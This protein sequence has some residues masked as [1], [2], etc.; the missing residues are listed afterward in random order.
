MRFLSNWKIA[1]R[2]VLLVLGG[3]IGMVTLAAIGLVEQRASL[4]SERQAKLRHLVETAHSLIAHYEALAAA[5]KTSVADAQRDALAALQKLRY[6]EKD[7]FWVNDM[8]PRMLMH[9]FATKLVG[10]DL[11]NNAD[12]TGLKLFVEFVKVVRAN[13]AGFVGYMWPKPGAENPVAKIS[14]VKGFA[15]WGWI[16]GTGVYV[17]DIEAAFRQAV[18][19]RIGVGAV[20]VL[21]VIGSCIIIT[22]SVTRPVA[23]MT[24]AMHRL[25]GKDW[26]TAVPALDRGDEIGQMAK[27]VQVFKDAGMENE[28]LESEAA[29]ARRRQALLEE[30]QRRV[31]DEA[32]RETERKLQ[33]LEERMRRNAEDQQAQDAA[34][35]AETDRVRRVA[36]LGMADTVER[37]TGKAV[38]DVHGSGK[39]LASDAEGMASSAA[40]MKHSAHTVA[41]AAEQ[42]SAS[43]QAVA[44]ATEEMSASIVE[45]GRQVNQAT[46]TTTKAVEASEQTSRTVKE[47]AQAVAKIEDV[48]KLINDIASQTGLL[49]LNAT[50]EAARAGEAGK[51]FAVVASEV[52]SLATQT[53]KST[54]DI[55]TLTLNIRE[56][57]SAAVSLIEDIAG[58]VHDIHTVS[59]MIA[60]SVS[61]QGAATREI[62]RNVSETTKAA[63]EVAERIA[64]VSTEAAATEARSAHVLELSTAVTDHIGELREAIVRV[65]RSATPESDRREHPRYPT[66]QFGLQGWIE[67]GAGRAN[68]H[69]NDIS[70]GGALLVGD[71]PVR[72]GEQVNVRIAGVAERIPARVVSRGDR[73]IGI[74]F[75]PPDDAARQ[76]IDTAV[77]VYKRRLERPDQAA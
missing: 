5:G 42:V 19:A 47:L 29:E 33:E 14:Y 13:G 59:G 44:A 34:R 52:K 32:A 62:A 39:E 76:Q 31:A 73:G 66:A 51:G 72:D 1:N 64:E 18:L 7:Y 24:S 49:A 15:P 71:A 10:E 37:E 11:S 9:P 53:A 63:V 27:A 70:R 26:Q 30:Q 3:V 77:F 35:Q 38:N 22:R 16:V 17:D 21:L 48:T 57:T 43:A 28:R 36:L 40:R 41:S 68:V 56:R 74:E 4:I 46:D 12:P 20:L 58:Q 69:V 25:A 50:I 55:A 6:E 75:L 8:Q 45:I 67:T 54:Q 60:T 23:A 65:V 61:Q 2:L